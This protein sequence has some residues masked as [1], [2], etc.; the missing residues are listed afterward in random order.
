[1]VGV[2]GYLLRAVHGGRILYM[3]AKLSVAPPLHCAVAAFRVSVPAFWTNTSQITF[4]FTGFQPVYPNQTL[5]YQWGLGTTPNATDTIPFTPF[6]GAQIPNTIFITDGQLLRNVTVF[7]QSYSLSN[8]T[9]LV[10][11]Q[12]YHVTVQAFCD[13]SAAAVVATQSATVR[14]R[15]IPFARHCSSILCYLCTLFPGGIWFL[16]RCAAVGFLVLPCLTCDMHSLTSAT[17][18]QLLSTMFLGCRLLAN[19]EQGHVPPMAQQVAMLLWHK[20]MPSC[21]TRDHTQAAGHFGQSSM[22]PG[23]PLY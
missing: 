18:L 13:E 6:T 3:L 23:F 22:L 4:N 19:T 5:Q 20:C 12:Q 21:I 10:E 16:H 15:S 8:A 17:Y 14:V 7:Q 9:A 11:G 1:M 2:W